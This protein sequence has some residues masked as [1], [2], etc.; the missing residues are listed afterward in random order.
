MQTIGRLGPVG[1]A[2]AL[3]LEELVEQN[4]VHATTVMLARAIEAIRSN[5]PAAVTVDECSSEETTAVVPSS[6]P[7]D[8]SG[9]L[10]QDHSGSELTFADA[11][12]GRLSIVVFFYTRCD[13]PARC[14]LTTYRFAACSGCYVWARR[15]NRD[16][17]HP[18]DPEYDR[19]ER[20]LRYAE[21]LGSEALGD[22]PNPSNARR[23]VAR[24]QLQRLGDRES[25]PPRGFRAGWARPDRS[26]PHVTSLTEAQLMRLA[27]RS[28][29]SATLGKNAWLVYE[30]TSETDGVELWR[31][32]DNAERH[33]A[34]RQH[35][36]SVLVAS[37]Q[38]SR[39]PLPSG[40]RGVC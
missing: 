26:R 20:L 11:L 16:G 4:P 14:P 40:R 17:G 30:S 5:V 12:H 3:R 9:L 6:P 33:N 27:L 31:A 10:F 19:A 23:P 13:N 38:L 2:C 29:H 34:L 28:A 39:V 36:G 21:K 15:F 22:A 35:L 24:R 25:T 8:L 18:Y 1:R 32:Q 37:H 7:T